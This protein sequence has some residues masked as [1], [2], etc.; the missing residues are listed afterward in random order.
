MRLIRNW[1]CWA[2]LAVRLLLGGVFLYAS[3]AKA[4]DPLDFADA[5]ASF[6]LL[7]A[8]W[9][10]PFALGLPTY[11][12]LLGAWL[13]SGWRLRTAAFGASATMLVFL[14]A[15]ASAKM[16]GLGVDCGCFGGGASPGNPGLALA[17]DAGL[18]LAALGLYASLASKSARLRGQVSG[19]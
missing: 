1:R 8:Y 4:R 2:R 5:V 9:I 13:L 19:P 3:I 15:L 12:I 16:R 6:H 10:N 17:R 18:A 14:A 11:E 7:P